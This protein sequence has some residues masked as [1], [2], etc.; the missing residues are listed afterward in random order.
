M[1]NIRI[2]VLAVFPDIL[3]TRLFLYKMPMSEIKENNST[4]NLRNRFKSKSVHLH[5]SLYLYAK[6]QDPSQSGSSDILFIRFF[7]YKMPMSVKG[8]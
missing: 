4:E 6:Y 1:P 3:F 8:E 7:L 5:F 2:L